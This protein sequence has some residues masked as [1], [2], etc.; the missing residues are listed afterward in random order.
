M[1]VKVLICKPANAAVT[2]VLCA[3][4]YATSHGYQVERS[5]R[6]EIDDQDGILLL[7]IEN[8][9][10]LHVTCN[11]VALFTTPS[12]W[13]WRRFFKLELSQK[14]IISSIIVFRYAL[15]RCVYAL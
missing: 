5:R 9:G 11:L 12:C 14:T 15:P 4:R 2:R 13:R 10:I 3:A 8:V 7:R 1:Y 6:S